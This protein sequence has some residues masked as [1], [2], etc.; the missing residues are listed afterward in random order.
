[1]NYSDSVFLRAC[2]EGPLAT[3]SMHSSIPL[4]TGTSRLGLT[5]HRGHAALATRG[6]LQSDMGLIS[7]EANSDGIGRVSFVDESTE[8]TL[9]D[10]RAAFRA[11]L[12]AGVAADWSLTLRN[13]LAGRGALAEVALD[14]K[15]TPF[16]LQVW[17]TLRS[18]RFGTRFSYGDLARRAGVP[19]AVRA[20]ASACAANQI[21]LFVPCHRVIRGD[22]E[23]GGYR[24]GADR[25]AALLSLEQNADLL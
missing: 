7:V 11:L 17:Q 20:V 21:A 15:G 3:M 14:L 13:Y 18:S 12:A 1:M 5:A 2:R 4:P 23:L 9:R 6:L 24:W 8:A 25:K 22:G 10:N 16:Q 19:L